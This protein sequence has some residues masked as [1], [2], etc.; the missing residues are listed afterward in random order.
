MNET[1]FNEMQAKQEISHLTELKYF[2]NI[3]L[4]LQPT[5]TK[6]PIFYN[7]QI[8]WPLDGRPILPKRERKEVYSDLRPYRDVASLDP[9]GAQHARSSLSGHVPSSPFSLRMFLLQQHLYGMIAPCPFG[10]VMVHF[11]KGS[12]PLHFATGG[13]H[14]YRHS[15]QPSPQH[16]AP[17][18]LGL[19]QASLRRVAHQKSSPNWEVT[20][21]VCTCELQSRQTASR[22]EKQPRLFLHQE[23]P[24]L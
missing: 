22:S 14:W 6:K 17:V 11:F 23:G 16:R 10:A 8:L 20:S 4:L 18:C 1:L 15:P 12:K 21:L 7:H 3:K 13:S 9:S 24:A 5:F 19:R 2:P